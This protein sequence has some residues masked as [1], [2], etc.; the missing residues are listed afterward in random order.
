MD[1]YGKWEWLKRL[2]EKAYAE[3]GRG[4]DIPED[5]SDS[6]LRVFEATHI[7]QN[8][9]RLIPFILWLRHF[10]DPAE[11]FAS[12][13]KLHP[14]TIEEAAH[15]LHGTYMRVVRASSTCQRS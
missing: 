4:I 5:T 10:K 2:C 12:I 14:T 1:L 15:K 11:L 6:P 9:F 8:Y 13:Y 3:F 7:E